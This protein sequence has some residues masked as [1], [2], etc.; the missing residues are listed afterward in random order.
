MSNTQCVHFI[1][2]NDATH[3]IYTRKTPNAIT[4]LSARQGDGIIIPLNSINIHSILVV[5]SVHNFRLRCT[6]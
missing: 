4:V 2:E 5:A 1:I 6:Q 3:A